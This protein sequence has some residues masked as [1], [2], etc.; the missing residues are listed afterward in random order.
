M[1]LKGRDLFVIPEDGPSRLF[2]FGLDAE[3]EPGAAPAARSQRRAIARSTSHPPMP[4]P[5]AAAMRA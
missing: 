1:A 5:P 3:A 2:H 4:A